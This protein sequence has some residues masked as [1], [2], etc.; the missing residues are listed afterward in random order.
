M[1]TASLQRD[2]TPTNECPE[3]DTK[4][5]DGEAPVIKLW[6]RWS[7]PLLS[8]FPGLVRPGVVVPVRI[9][10]IGQIELFNYF[11]VSKQLTDVKIVSVR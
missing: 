1:P 5:S 2:K 11:T 8:L 3:Y 4:T 10:S 9:P 7:T 6:G